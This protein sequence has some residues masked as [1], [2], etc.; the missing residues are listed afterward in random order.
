ML[1]QKDT[2]FNEVSDYPYEKIIW[3]CEM[4]ILANKSNINLS[5]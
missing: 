4:N 1:N 5:E 3:R 2:C